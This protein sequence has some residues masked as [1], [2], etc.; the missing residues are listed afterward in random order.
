VLVVTEVALAF[1]LLTGRAADSQ[2]LPDAAGEYGF[3]STNRAD[4]RTADPDKRYPDPAQLNAYLRQVVS[5]VEALPGVRDVA[6]TSALADAGVGIRACRF[7]GR[8]SRWWIAPTGAPASFKMVSPSYFRTL[9]MEAAQGADAGRARCEGRAGCG[10]VSTRPW[11]RL[12]FKDEEPIGQAHSGAGDCPGKTQL[13]PE[14]PL[15]NRRRVA[16]EK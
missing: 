2:F 16:D 15:G 4:R 5:N 10:G 14:I 13:G 8:T 12:H 3:D 7:S 1:V 9:G 6:L 11:L